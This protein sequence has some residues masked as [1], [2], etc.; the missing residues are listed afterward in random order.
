MLSGTC[1]WGLCSLTDVASKFVSRHSGYKVADL[2]SA[3]GY[4][5]LP[6][7]KTFVVVRDDIMAQDYQGMR[8]IILFHTV[9]TLEFADD[10]YILFCFN[11]TYRS[12]NGHGLS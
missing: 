2:L 8:Q 5:I 9:L 10:S 11:R 7:R 12:P 3:Q 6:L 4:T 1:D